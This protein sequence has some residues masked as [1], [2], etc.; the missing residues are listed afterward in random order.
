MVTKK[1]HSREPPGTQGR[2]RSFSDPVNVVNVTG[3]R[4]GG[5]ELKKDGY[6]CSSN[7]N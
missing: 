7:C 5:E 6:C 1:V 4:V 3:H 2:L